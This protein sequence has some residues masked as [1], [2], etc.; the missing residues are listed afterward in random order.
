MITFP[1][2]KSEIN[3]AVIAAR[4]VLNVTYWIT[5]N[6]RKIHDSLKDLD[7]KQK[8]RDQNIKKPPIKVQIKQAV[9]EEMRGFAYEGVTMADLERFQDKD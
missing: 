5:L 8:A 2:T 7:N 6:P 1:P 3:K 4:P 9:N